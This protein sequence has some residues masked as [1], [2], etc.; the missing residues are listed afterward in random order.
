[1]K[2]GNK[3]KK[4]DQKK[5]T[6]VQKKYKQCCSVENTNEQVVGS[7]RSL[8]TQSHYSSTPPYASILGASNWCF[9]IVNKKFT[10][11]MPQIYDYTKHIIPDE[12]EEGQSH[13]GAQ[14]GWNVYE[15]NDALFAHIYEIQTQ[16]TKLYQ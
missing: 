16:T 15:G 12:M 9:Q 3:Y 8:A 11:S 4:Y 6:T 1:M 10:K 5:Y 2:L 14:Y 13:P 7:H